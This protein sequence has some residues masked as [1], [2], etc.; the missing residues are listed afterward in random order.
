MLSQ[1]GVRAVEQ[2]LWTTSEDRVYALLDGASV[3]GL[4]D[5]LYGAQRPQFESLITGDLTADMAEVSPYLV[6]LERQTEFADW[7]ITQGWG[8]HWG[9]YAVGRAD[10]RA[11]WF[12]LRTLVHVHG[13]DA[14]PMLFRFYDPR[15]LRMF[16][17]TCTPEQVKE[18]F[19][20]LDRF[21]AESDTP[22]SALIFTQVDGELQTGMRQISRTGA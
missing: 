13:P 22:G 3:S 11:T 12:H 19:G 14:K 5:R 15:V 21:V 7:V 16:L 9:L 2:L 8:N 17:P 10:L 1:E 20:T 6:A 4:L 18:M